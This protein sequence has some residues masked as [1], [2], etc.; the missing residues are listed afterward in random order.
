MPKHVGKF[1]IA[2]PIFILVKPKT[3]AK[4]LK[5]R[6]KSTKYHETASKYETRKGKIYLLCS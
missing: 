5:L 1:K 3:I 6:N 2:Y 4:L